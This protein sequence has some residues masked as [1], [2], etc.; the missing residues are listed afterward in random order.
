MDYFFTQ[1]T[2]RSSESFLLRSN[3]AST[4]NALCTVLAQT[5]ILRPV[6]FP[7]STLLILSLLRADCFFSINN[8]FALSII[9]AAFRNLGTFIINELDIVFFRFPLSSHKGTSAFF[10]LC[11]SRLFLSTGGMS[12]PIYFHRNPHFLCALSGNWDGWGRVIVPVSD[13]TKFGRDGAGD[14]NSSDPRLKG[15][16]DFSA[17]FEY[18]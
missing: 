11:I 7:F 10:S 17:G 1:Y 18:R 13:Y 2:L 16:P 8:A 12:P 6:L 14:S 9:N 3:R 4:H 5:Q 15:E